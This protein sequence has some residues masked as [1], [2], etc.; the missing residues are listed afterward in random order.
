MKGGGGVLS[1]QLA[2]R[3]LSMDFKTESKADG[4]EGQKADIVRCTR[5]AAASGGADTVTI[6][7]AAGAVLII[8]ITNNTWFGIVMYLLT[9]SKRYKQPVDILGVG[10]GTSNS[11]G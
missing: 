9:I 5:A 2:E 1:V 3:T 6:S 8:I 11:S 4:T 10:C 7:I